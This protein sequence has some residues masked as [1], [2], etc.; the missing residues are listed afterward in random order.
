MSTT[1]ASENEETKNTNIADLNMK[2]APVFSKFEETLE[3]MPE[4]VRD[5]PAGDPASETLP[6]KQAAEA[7]AAAEQGRRGE[8]PASR[9]TLLCEQSARKENRK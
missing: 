5:G 3:F 4:A 1:E 8:D 9:L 7:R 2:V 6:L